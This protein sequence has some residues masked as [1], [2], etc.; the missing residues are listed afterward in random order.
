MRRRNYYRGRGNSYRRRGNAFTDF[1]SYYK[2]RIFLV[3]GALALTGAGVGVAIPIL[4]SNSKNGP[5]IGNGDIDNGVGNNGNSN[6]II[7]DDYDKKPIEEVTEVLY[8]KETAT[9]DKEMLETYVDTSI[10]PE[11]AIL[12]YTSVSQISKTQSR[13]SFSASK[14]YD[15]NGEI[16][17][18]PSEFYFPLEIESTEKTVISG[19]AEMQY[20]RNLSIEEL[21]ILLYKGNDLTWKVDVN[22]PEVQKLLYIENLPEDANVTF[23]K[24]DA[25]AKRNYFIVSI[26]TNKYFDEEMGLVSKSK[27]FEEIYIYH[28]DIFKTSFANNE[29]EING[30]TESYLSKTKELN[31]P[32]QID[33][34]DVTKI[35]NR[36]FSDYRFIRNI[37]FPSDTLKHIG[38]FAFA[39]TRS[40]QISGT[41]SLPSSLMTIG[42]YAFAGASNIGSISVESPKYGDQWWLGYSSDMWERIIYR[43]GTIDSGQNE[44]IFDIKA[45][46]DGYTITGIKYSEMV[47]DNNYYGDII[48]PDEINGIKVKAIAPFA[49]RNSWPSSVLWIHGKVVI[50]N[51]VEV[52]GQSAFEGQGEVTELTI[53]NRV[54]SIEKNA[55]S[56]LSKI[57]SVEIPDSVLVIGESAFSSNRELTEVKFGND[58]EL[59]EIRSSAF[60][61]N[62]K[63][64]SFTITKRVTKILGGAFGYC[65]ELTQINWENESEL[66]LNG[67]TFKGS[68]KL[69]LDNPDHTIVVP[70][71]VSFVYGDVFYDVGDPYGDGSVLITVSVSEKLFNEQE[72]WN[73][74]FKG[75][76]K[77]H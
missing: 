42:N 54:E 59:Y 23:E 14:Y 18:T 24:I 65:D 12:K 13:M 35:G 46:N 52:V 40:L 45:E 3:G 55:F 30:L 38:D 71:N 57:T 66:K 29:Y 64:K 48:I 77:K 36:A 75:I 11:D 44:T 9:I 26:R 4:L 56:D 60:S 43:D 73:Q 74:N 20:K 61:Q 37:T 34:F 10:F 28:E 27:L 8:D 41:L 21:E 63:L 22:D 51:N 16:V 68:K 67:F 15:E 49:F 72:K 17:D 58:P 70:S 33:G 6:I 76:I 47:D 50:G 39:D 32:R 5:G 53:G 31:I 62:K 2:T 25:D 69:G 7:K 19:N 1:F